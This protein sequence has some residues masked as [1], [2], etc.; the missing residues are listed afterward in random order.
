MA[1]W[2]IKERND[3]VRA[4]QDELN[5][6]GSRGIF[7]GGFAPT[8]SAGECDIVDYISIAHGGLALDF[9]NLSAA[10]SQNAGFGS[11]SRAICSGGGGPDNGG[12]VMN[13]P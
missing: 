6:Q 12:D 11:N 13:V 7:M 5:I 3:L 8:V 2:D 1:V 10:R 4:N 9:G